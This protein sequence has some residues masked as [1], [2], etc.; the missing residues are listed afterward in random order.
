MLISFGK[1]TLSSDRMAEFCHVVG[2]TILP[3]WIAYQVGYGLVMLK[4]EAERRA[5]DAEHRAKEAEKK[6]AWALEL[7]KGG[8]S[9]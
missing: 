9:A 8:K 7:L 6:L 4:T 5:D 3:Q 2:N 1:N